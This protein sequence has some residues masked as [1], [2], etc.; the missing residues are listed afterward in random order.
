MIL[1]IGVSIHSEIIIINKFGLNEYTKKRLGKKGDED[2]ELTR[3]TTNS[4]FND[5]V[6]LKKTLIIIEKVQQMK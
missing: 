1:I 2:V 4:S 5:E 3:K 6:L